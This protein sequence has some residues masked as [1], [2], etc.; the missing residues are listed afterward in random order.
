MNDHHICETIQSARVK[1][2]ITCRNAKPNS[3]VKKKCIFRHIAYINII[4]LF[5]QLLLNLNCV[6]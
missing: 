4:M 6:L 2:T 3:S 5:Q 1:R